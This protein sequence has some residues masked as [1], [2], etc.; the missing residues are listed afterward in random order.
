MLID[1]HELGP[2]QT[3][4]K[5]KRD[6]GVAA[7]ILAGVAINEINNNRGAIKDVAEKLISRSIPIYMV[8]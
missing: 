1:S 8:G 2:L 3:G 5:T 6:G 4:R 7:A